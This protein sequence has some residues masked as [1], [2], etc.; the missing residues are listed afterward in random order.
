MGSTGN[1]GRQAAQ[2]QL[3]ALRAIPAHDMLVDPGQLELVLEE[4]SSEDLLSRAALIGWTAGSLAVTVIAAIWWV[5][6]GH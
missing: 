6:S 1:D 4:P 2:T 3:D 5:V